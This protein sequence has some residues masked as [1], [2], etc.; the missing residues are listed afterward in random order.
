MAAAAGVVLSA[1]AL[2]AA[3]PATRPV[4]AAR[5]V[6]LI[7]EAI[8]G[9]L[10]LEGVEV[11][12]RGG[13]ELRGLEVYDPHGHLVLSAGRAR[14]FTDITG[15][16]TRS[17]GLSVEL[18]SPSVLLEEEPG[19][20]VSIAR[21]FAS[22]RK[23]AP[24]PPQGEEPGDGGGGGWTVHV[25]RLTVRRGDLWWVDG[26]GGTRLEARAL[27]LDARGLVGPRRARADLSLRGELAVPVA[28]PVALDLAGELTGDAVRVPVL[29][30]EVAGTS[31]AVVGQGDLARRT[32]RVA[33]GR[34]G[35]SRE[36]ARAFVPRAPRGDDL[37]ASGYAETDGR[38]LVV[39][40][41]A[42]PGEGGGRGRAD[43]ALAARLAAPAA[44]FGFDV[45]LDR[46]DPSRLVADAPAGEVTLAGR[47]GLAGRSLRD[48]R[49]R[50]SATVERSRLR[51]G[52]VDRAEVQARAEPGTVEVTRLK[53]SAPGA[54]AEGSL[55]WREGGEVAGRMS[56]DAKD[57]AA[58]VANAGALLGRSL[59]RVAGSARITASLAGTSGAPTATLL[60]DAPQLRVGAV[61]LA[62]VHLQG[63]LAGPL[64]TA[65]ARV[66]G[67]VAAVR[68][69]AREVARGVSLRA[70]LG[71]EL[72]EVTAVAMLPGFHDPATLAA[73]G[74]LG[75]RRETLAVSELA[76]AYPG[77]RWALTQPATVTFAGPTVDRLEITSGGQRIAITGG[78][79]RGRTLDARL[80]VAALELARLPEGLLPAGQVVRGALTADLSA[81]G[82]A[83]RPELRGTFSL[84]GGGFRNLEGLSLAG[85]ARW[86]GG[87]RRVS[88]SAAL[89]RADGGAVDVEA[90]VPLPLAGRPAERV[91]VRA[92]AREVPL[93][94][95]LPAAEVD[96]PAAGRLG[97]ELALEG[98][99]GAPTL[100]VGATLGDGEWRDL[101][102]LRIDL[103]AEDPGE[104]LRLTVHGALG[105]VRRVTL[106]VELPLDVSE[107]L[108]RPAAALRAARAAPL[109]GSLLVTKLDLASLSGRAGVPTRLAGI[110]DGSASL[111]G[112]LA[113]P[114]ATAGLDL[115]GGAF[116]GYPDL[117]GHL[118]LALGQAEVTA[119]AGLALAA[120]EA[121][122]LQVSLGAPVERLLT[123][124]GLRR[125]AL[126][127]EVRVPGLDLARAVSRDVPLGG[128]VDARLAVAGTLGAP[129]ARLSVA[130][131][132][133]TVEGRPLGKA[134]LDARHASARTSGEG[135][136]EPAAGGKL[137]VSFAVAWDPGLGAAR[138]PL[139][140][141]PVEAALVAESLD[142]GFLPAAAPG[143]VRAAGG[144][145]SADLRATGPL[146]RPSPRGT[147]RVKDGRLAVAE[148]GEWTRITVD[149]SLAEDAVELS[150]LE[151]HRGAGR[152]GL[153]GSVRGL[154]GPA[155][156][157]LEAHLVSEG[158]TLA[159]YGMD[160]ATV[161]LRADAT[162]R[163][164][165]STLGVDVLVPKGLVRLP[166]RQPRELQTLEP[167]KDIVVG[168]A[169]ER[170]RRTKP[171]PG[172]APSAADRPLGV[173]ARVRVDRNLFV[174][175]DDPRV[176]VELKADVEYERT[177]GEDYAQGFVEVIRGSVEPLAGRT[178][179]LERGRVQ[180]TGGPPGASMLDVQA[181]YDN[182]AAVVTVNVQGP[183]GKPEI[184]LHS[185]PPMDDAQIAM[186]IATGR[187]E[188]KA[189]SGGVGTLTGEE[190]GKAALAALAT[191]AFK[192]L[193]ANKLPLDTVALES[194]ALRAGKYVTD[195]IYVGY[196]RRF[197]ADPQRGENADEVRVE[198]Q[199]TPRW[200]FES[201]YG[202]AQSGGAS[203]IWS[204][205]Y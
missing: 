58:A 1:L 96:S 142:L 178:F 153:T 145:L 69:G 144:T 177:G 113:A 137:R 99:V 25:S 139:R 79:V 176:D 192:D 37:A 189:G 39:A 114:R 120:E 102:D 106:D 35:L 112:S 108:S 157:A 33:I 36:T 78:L 45:A 74:R 32:G 59:A 57:L 130:G 87:E 10:V 152:V 11:L 91:R 105:D 84:A 6:G 183:T 46:L 38:S 30:A 48:L 141:A 98:T 134:R 62:D 117:S 159:R 131:E 170:K 125:A 20:G 162:G 51:G 149:A 175:S 143:V 56:G 132:G 123:K 63:D 135:V 185:E 179:Q 40:V 107:L 21:A 124:E 18:E 103:T 166:S 173:K 160:V 67:R 28:G 7:D 201:R 187:L 169:A 182:P 174:R 115:R 52:R 154:R 66:E 81:T 101:G 27:D 47:G 15:L 171:Q 89:S 9:S 197:D 156:A 12:A 128:T 8:A 193:V 121:L 186:L 44:A 190:A 72:A 136:L 5:V 77:A 172:P 86:S 199:I 88:A 133:I 22:P 163:W 24:S 181:R 43:A 90:D 41:R 119:A 17:V 83:A 42:E 151:V 93:E 140:D 64:A 122:R 49:G 129:E 73:R 95:L 168:R 14:V 4:V 54:E 104:R 61:G 97:L 138:G 92:R 53:V 203:L 111:S 198:Y 158:F 60:V 19:G 26:R 70:A 204:R 148:L 2:L 110:V 31:L 147:L 167:R 116:A 118:D 146:G 13:I 200:T 191:Q 164:D 126:R 188:L 71:N 127:V 161:D 165:G 205:Q 80:E 202:N 100:S 155:P 196:T 68:G 23:G 194:G 65:S 29:R 16:R 94:E 85:S 82:P 76:F 75:A 180:F 184:Q 55:R 109:E 34:L 3:L 50:I 150:R 195:K